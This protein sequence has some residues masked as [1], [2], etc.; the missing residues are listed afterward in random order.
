MFYEY[1]EDGLIETATKEVLEE[2]GWQITN[3][4][5]IYF[6]KNIPYAKEGMRINLRNMAFMKTRVN[7]K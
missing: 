7:M 6:S 4:W 1:S 5:N 3:A 2:L